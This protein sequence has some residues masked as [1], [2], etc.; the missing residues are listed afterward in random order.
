MF[1]EH[2]FSDL[3]ALVVVCLMLIAAWGLNGLIA[4]LE[5]FGRRRE[6]RQR[7]KGRRGG[8]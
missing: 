4:I 1:S 8:S 5:E 6:Q 3:M 2:F 7:Q